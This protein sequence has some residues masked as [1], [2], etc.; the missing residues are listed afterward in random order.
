[1]NQFE[2]FI[3]L[4]LL[5]VFNYVGGCNVT[6]CWILDILITLKNTRRFT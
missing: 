6:I 5:Q 4:A 1:M 3:D 2:S